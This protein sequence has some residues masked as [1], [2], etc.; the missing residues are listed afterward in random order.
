MKRPQTWQDDEGLHLVMPNAGR[1]VAGS[2]ANGVKV[3]QVADSVEVI[4]PV[5]PGS[6]VSVKPGANRLDVVVGGRLREKK[7]G[8]NEGAEVDG[9]SGRDFATSSQNRDE[10]RGEISSQRAQIPSNP[11]ASSGLTATAPIAP[12]AALPA[13]PIQQTALVPGGT[14][15]ALQSG[16]DDGDAMFA[17]IPSPLVLVALLGLGIGALVVVRQRK[18]SEDDGF[19]NVEEVP[20][21]NGK[22]LEKRAAARQVFERRQADRRADLGRRGTDLTTGL[23]RAAQLTASRNAVNSGTGPLS[24]S[25]NGGMPELFGAYRVDQEVGKL[26]IGQPHRMDVLG[27]RAPDDR[28]AIEASLLKYINSPEADAPGLRRA[29]TALEEYGFVARQ[30]AALLLANSSFERSA[31]ARSLGDIGSAAALPFL[32]EALY[33]HEEIVRI[34]AVSS[35][36]ALRLPSAIGALLDMA[37]HH[38]EMPSDVI[39]RA[40]SA[41]SVDCFDIGVSVPIDGELLALGD[42]LSFT[43][44]IT[45]LDRPDDVE[46]LPENSD[47]PKFFGLLDAVRNSH[48]E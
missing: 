45:R 4:I 20:V 26:V 16:Q 35:L 12:G 36:G 31:A 30:S 10:I 14:L 9:S 5:K 1:N 15:P 43:G 34:Q 11:S 28:R 46:E 38:P 8:D 7:Q 37:R 2:Y 39:S 22:A 6:G 41:C 18:R 33:D 48:G 21:G 3:R 17:M 47:D 32:L 44:E 23:D 42:G 19:E 29:R 25:Q 40:L 13:R 27:S 24:R